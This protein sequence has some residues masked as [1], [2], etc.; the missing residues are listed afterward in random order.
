VDPRPFVLQYQTNTGPRTVEVS[1]VKQMGR[2]RWHVRANDARLSIAGAF[3]DTLER[4]KAG[5]ESAL[6]KGYGDAVPLS[7]S[8]A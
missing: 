7:W 4:A 6:R 2:I 5:V 3:F 1:P 8:E